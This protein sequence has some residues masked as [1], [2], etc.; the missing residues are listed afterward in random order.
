MKSF[1]GHVLP[2]DGWSPSHKLITLLGFLDYPT[3]LPAIVSTESQVY[4]EHSVNVRRENEPTDLAVVQPRRN[5][6]AFS[7]QLFIQ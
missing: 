7:P 1:L 3:H 5:R 2:R 6:S 4:P